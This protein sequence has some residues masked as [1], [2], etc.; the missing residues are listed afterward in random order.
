MATRNQLLELK[1]EEA[2]FDRAEKFENVDEIDLDPLLDRIGDARVVLIGEASHGTSEF[3]GIRAHITRKLIAEKD[4]TIVAAEADWPDAARID[5]YV[6][7]REYPPSEWTAF[8]RFP[9]WMWR[10]HEVRAFVDW[11][12]EWNALIPK[13]DHRVGFYGLD[14]YSLFL[15]VD[16]VIDYLQGIDPEAAREAVHRYSCLMGWRHDPAGYGRAAISGRYEAC[17][18]AVQAMLRDLL[19]K[20]GAYALHDGERFLDAAQNARL[21]ANA[22]KY[23]RI[24]YL[25][26]PESWNLRDRHMHET[27]L[28]VMEFRGA[29]SKAVI[30][31]HNSHV[32]DA[33]ATDMTKRGELNI[34]QL[35]RKS[36]GKDAYHIGMGTHTG[37]VAAATDW[38]SHMEI[39]EVKPSLPESYERLCHE[40]GPNRFLLPLREEHAG[41]ARDA[42]MERRLERAIGVIYRPESERLSHYF[43]ATLPLQFDEYIWFDQTRAVTPI[44]THEAEGLPDTYP[45]GI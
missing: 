27:L 3:Y 11:L 34:G 2:I 36:F 40:F 42:L 4:F 18:D 1:A 24:M 15:S 5:H 21:V 37:T 12:R 17:T 30:W 19:E 39:K 14:L 28:R 13:P 7:H 10:N 44:E 26:A 31:A 32:G 35:C 9:T 45:F 8:S 33:R 38:G 6:Q 43:H 22:E 20:C 25:G 23:Y 41:V 16:A 29:D